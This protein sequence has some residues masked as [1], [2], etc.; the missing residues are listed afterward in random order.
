LTDLEW[1]YL[2]GDFGVEVAGRT[3]RIVAPVRQL[4]LSDWTRQGLPFYAG[5]VTYHC[6][7]TGTGQPLALRVPRFVA[8][9]LTVTVDGRRAGPIAFPP[10]QLDLGA[11]TGG[12]HR[13]D[14]T[15]FGSRI[16][17]FGQL[18]NCNP[19]EKWWGPWSY[20]SKDDAWSYEYQLKAQG[21]L[22]APRVLT[23][24]AKEDNP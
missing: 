24:E 11:L 4:H 17:A 10:Y 20:R 3:A 5:N 8:P 1:C 9:L 14:I 18:H 16:N 13:L 23:A 22:V 15:A 21:L 2:L 6:R 7:A 19:N 12:E